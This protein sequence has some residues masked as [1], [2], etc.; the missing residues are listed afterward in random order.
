MLYSYSRADVTLPLALLYVFYVP[1]VMVYYLT[2]S[3]LKRTAAACGLVGKPPDTDTPSHQIKGLRAAKLPVYSTF[4]GDILGYIGMMKG[5]WKP[6]YEGAQRLGT[7]AI[8]AGLG[9]PWVVLTGADALETAQALRDNSTSAVAKW[10]TW[11]FEGMDLFSGLTSPK[12]LKFH[13]QICAK[14]PKG[15]EFAQ[16]IA[17][18]R[19]E[20]ASW[21]VL[22]SED[23]LNGLDSTEL[24]LRASVSFASAFLLGGVIDVELVG[25]LYPYP[26]NL[27]LFPWLPFANVCLP[28]AAKARVVREKLYEQMKAMPRWPDVRQLAT[29]AGLN[30]RQALGDVLSI[31]L[32]NADGLSNPWTNALAILKI[33]PLDTLTGLAADKSKREA[34]AWE[35]MR[36]N[37]PRSAQV[38]TKDVQIPDGG[39][40]YSIK[41]GT[42]ILGI[43]GL[44]QMDETVYADPWVF[45]PERFA[46]PPPVGLTR[47][48]GG[49]E[50]FPT[51]GQ[52]LKFGGL[53]DETAATA[54]C[55]CPFV[56]LTHPVIL[57]FVEMLLFDFEYEFADTKS[58]GDLS[59]E[60]QALLSAGGIDMSPAR[61]QTTVRA[62]DFALASKSGGAFD[63]KR[64]AARSAFAPVALKLPV[65]KGVCATGGVMF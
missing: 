52:G 17:A 14:D 35:L 30:E 37:G 63:F 1:V 18:L 46:P 57:A 65:R 38:A 16:G 25:D 20:L 29:A 49:H 13:F 48:A 40:V 51:M 7:G 6:L 10:Q 26:A 33:L 41:K 9:R 60:K 44:A 5:G 28:G 36:F 11:L 56:K 39:N 22:H 47:P 42:R 43:L 3:L 61:L 8:V 54:K 32:L 34:L 15:A 59:Q 31:I 53:A 58:R 23:R 19:A 27:P 55:V 62:T 64:F 24:L 4:V 21:C 12:M 45:K 50:P 2:I